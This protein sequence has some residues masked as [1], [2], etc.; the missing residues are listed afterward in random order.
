[1][2]KKSLPQT[3]ADKILA[4]Y[5]NDETIHL[6]VKLPT[7]SELQ[8]KY[9]ISRTTVLKAIDILRERNIVYSIQ[10]KGTFFVTDRLSLYL[11]GI[12]SYDYQLSKSGIILENILLSS[13]ICTANDEVAK[14]LG[15]TLGDKVIE[16]IRKKVDS[17]T[18]NDLI[19]QCNYLNLER[20]PNLNFD[21]LNHQRLYSI[22]GT[23]FNLE[24]TSASEQIMIS[25]VEKRLGNYLAEKYNEVMRIDRI[26]YEND[27][28]VEYTHTYLLTN[29]FKYDVKLDMINPL[30]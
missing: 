9:Y 5:L 10:G 24:L 14:K 21:K 2:K 3:I 22:L 8:K 6:G 19:L 27:L 23:D 26:S 4:D 7:Q 25:L 28:A 13:K 11:N 30:F 17:K 29:S 20:F 16:I 15:V 12:Y 18:G 1:M